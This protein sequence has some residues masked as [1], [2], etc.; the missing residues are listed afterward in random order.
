MKR[1]ELLGGV[2]HTY[3]A[4]RHQRLAQTAGLL[5]L[6]VPVTVLSLTVGYKT[7]CEIAMM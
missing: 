7:H 1:C 4:N 3:T 5:P 2:L 6:P